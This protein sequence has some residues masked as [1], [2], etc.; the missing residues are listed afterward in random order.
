M[1]MEITGQGIMPENLTGDELF[2]IRLS[3]EH[4]DCLVMEKRKS[5]KGGSFEQ[6]TLFLEDAQTG[7]EKEL[8]YMFKKTFNPLSK[9]WTKDSKSWIGN[10][11]QIKP[12]LINDYWE[13]KLFPVATALKEETIKN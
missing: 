11:I 2:N 12:S 5:K 9:Q 13:V 10:T 8:K 4:D 6:Y 3:E 1:E 7:E